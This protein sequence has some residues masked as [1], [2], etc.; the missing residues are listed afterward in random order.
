MNQTPKYAF[1]KSPQNVVEIIA[2]IHPTDFDAMKS[3]ELVLNDW[4]YKGISPK[5][6]LKLE[7]YRKIDDIWYTAVIKDDEGLNSYILTT[8]HRILERKLLGRIKK[9]YHKKR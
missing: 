2:Q 1:V 4:S 6:P 3:L 7:L 9:D 5:N 8:F